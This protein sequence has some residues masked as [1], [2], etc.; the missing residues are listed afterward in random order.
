MDCCGAVASRR[1]GTATRVG[2]PETVRRADH[3]GTTELSRERSDDPRR[4]SRIIHVASGREWRGGQHQVLLLARGLDRHGIVTTV[5]TGAGT[6]LAGRLQAAGA[7]V[8]AVDWTVGLDPRIAIRLAGL[9]S[10]DTIVHAPD[11]Q[12]HAVAD[13]V[14]L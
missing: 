13:L 11:R 8:E 14:T 2:G 7:A 5:V 6:A 10:R 4:V 12:S 1:I 3:G 9:L